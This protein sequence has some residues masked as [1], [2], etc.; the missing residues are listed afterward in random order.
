MSVNPKP[1][2]LV[3]DDDPQDR[4]L[5]ATILERDGFGIATATNA[6]EARALL[7]ER[8][9]ALVIT[10]LTMPGETGL[11]LVQHVLDE[12]PDTGVLIVSGR[13][14]PAA[15]AEI[16]ELGIYGYL[17]K[18]FGIDQF[19]ITIANALRRRDLERERRQYELGLEWAVSTRTAELRRSREETVQKLASAM[20]YRDGETGDHSNRVGQLAWLIARGLGLDDQRCEL[21]RIAAPLHD[22][23]KI[24]IPD[25]ILTKPGRLDDEELAIMKRHAEIGGELLSGSQH[26]FLDL[27]ATVARSH[28]ER[29]N[30]SGYPDGLVGTACPWEARLVGIVDVFDALGHARCY[31]AAWS[32]RQ[33]VDYFEAEAG[34]LFDPEM[35]RVLVAIIPELDAVKSEYPDPIAGEYASGSRLKL[36][37][38]SPAVAEAEYKL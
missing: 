6:A 18:P 30:G 13:S 36:A 27:A 2:L 31:K 25:A 29:W 28:H 24:A 32:R 23:G 14:S 26:P 21:I 7:L 20:E 4:K 22:I 12:H 5:L 37:F 15:A 1:D 33:L 35:A 10:D 8:D 9:F 38:G 34:T 16:L 3:V 19:L 11:S 17:V